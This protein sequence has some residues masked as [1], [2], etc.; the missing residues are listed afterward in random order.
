MEKK[1][2]E[3]KDY[4]LSGLR[5]GNFKF[6]SFLFRRFSKKA[7]WLGTESCLPSL[8]VFCV[9]LYGP[10]R[11]NDLLDTRCFCEGSG[12]FLIL[13]FLSRLKFFYL[14]TKY[15]GRL[16]IKLFDGLGHLRSFSL[17]SLSGFLAKPAGQFPD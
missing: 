2:W 6:C 14:V 13:S 12:Y 17:I 16:E 7:G 8:F 15:R 9:R 1:K 5:G 3:T 11:I 10:Q 4:L